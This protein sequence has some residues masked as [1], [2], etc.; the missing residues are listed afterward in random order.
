MINTYSTFSSFIKQ[1]EK[2][3]LSEYNFEYEREFLISTCESII[4]EIE[5]EKH[6]QIKEAMNNEL[7]YIISK[8]KGWF[9]KL[10]KS[11]KEPEDLDYVNSKLLLQGLDNP[12]NYTDN[13]YSEQ[14]KT[15]YNLLNK[16]RVT[17]KKTTFINEYQKHFL[18]L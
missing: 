12:F 15:C 9:R 5:K 3:T 17:N 16:L 8:N 18:N 14:R 11:L 10:F 2:E 1:Q 7:S 13:V 4:Q 6:E